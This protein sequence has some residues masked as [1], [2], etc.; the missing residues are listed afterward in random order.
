MVGPGLS[1]GTDPQVPV[2]ESMQNTHGCMSTGTPAGIHDIH[3]ISTCQ[4]SQSQLNSNPTFSLL[5]SHSPLHVRSCIVVDTTGGG[6]GQ[7]GGIG[8]LHGCRCRAGGRW[9]W[10]W[11]V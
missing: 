3:S 8:A 2:R 10:Q 5:M 6:G 11:L 7:C 9:H 4:V 1:V